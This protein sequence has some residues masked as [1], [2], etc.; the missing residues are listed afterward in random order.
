[1]RPDG[2]ALL[3][4]RHTFETS[5]PQDVPGQSTG[6]GK[7]TWQVDQNESQI[8]PRSHASPTQRMVDRCLSQTTRELAPIV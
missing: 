7:D 3:G 8:T 6:P 2:L 5:S 4:S 1:M